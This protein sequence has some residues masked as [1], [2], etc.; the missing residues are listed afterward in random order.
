MPSTK[1]CSE[2]TNL[3][4]RCLNLFLAI[5][6]TIFCSPIIALISLIIVWKMGVP[7]FFRQQR[8]GLNQHPFVL[9]KFRS[10]EMTKTEKE[11]YSNT[12]FRTTSLG[13]F[14]RK[15]SLDELP[16]LWNVIK[17]EMSLVGPRPL[18]LHYQDR[19]SPKQNDRHKVPPG[20]TGLA[21]INGRKSISW[22]EKF[23]FD[24][25]YVRKRS[26][27][28]DI[29]ILFKTVLALLDRKTADVPGEKEMPDFNKLG[30]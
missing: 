3:R 8:I 21:Q 5:P 22:E 2:K 14:L 17:G 28:L 29:L 23:L 20:L 11:S 6:I 16:E 30:H 1:T 12:E 10:M 19:F 7:I 18:P 26:V 9:I 27:C 25:I 24:Q 15:T 4:F 13:R